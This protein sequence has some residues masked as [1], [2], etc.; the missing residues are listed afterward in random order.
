MEGIVLLMV[1]VAPW[2]Y[3]AVD[4]FSEYLLF[5]SVALIGALWAVRTA[6]D[7][8][9]LWFSCPI[10]LCLVLL[11]VLGVVQ[12]FPLPKY[13]A[14]IASPAAVSLNAELRPHQPE[15]LREGEPPV[16]VTP[17][18]TISVYP[19]ATQ[20][21]L[22][23][24]LALIVLFAAIRVNI[25]STAA[26]Q[27][28]AWVAFAT[29]VA[30]SVF[31]VYQFAQQRT[32]GPHVPVK[33]FGNETR[34]IPFGPFICRNHFPDFINICIGLAIGLLLIS[35]RTESD[36]RA[37]RT[38]KAQALVEQT[39]ED[40]ST[41]TLLSILHSPLQ[42]WLAVGLAI[43]AGAVVCSFSRGGVVA[44]FLGL[45]V[46][47]LIRGVPSA[48]RV[49]RLELLIIPALL[50]VGLL[51]WLGIKPLESRLFALNTETGS[52]GRLMIWRN[53]LPLVWRFPLF[54][55]GAGT[56]QY[57]EP[58]TRS[59]D[60]I[61]A[62]GPVDLD[63][64]HNDYLEAL[65]EGGVGRLLLTIAV[66]YFLIRFGRQ[67]MRRHELRTPGRM[68][69]GALIGI[70]AL[71]IH[72]FVDFGFTTPAV[73]WLAVVTA[74]YLS[75]MARSDP[76]EPPTRKSKHAI[77]VKAGGMGGIA[78]AVGLMLIGLVLLHHG[79]TATRV[80]QLR[81]SAFQAMRQMNPPNPDLA[82]T[83]LQVAVKMTPEN[84]QLRSELGQVFLDELK[85]QR[86][87]MEQRRGAA[88][89]VVL[90]GSHPLGHLVGVSV[91]PIIVF[92]SAA[93]ARAEFDE[94]IAPGLTNMIAARD[95]CPLLARPHARLAL[96]A[97]DAHP[98]SGIVMAKSDPALDYWARAVRLTPFDAD[99]LYYYGQTLF[100]AGREDQ[101]WDVWRRSL[102]QK[103]THLKA[104]IAVASTKLS[105][106]ELINRLLPDDPVVLLEVARFMAARPDMND[107][108]RRII[109]LAKKSLLARS[110][111][112]DAEATRLLGQCHRMLGETEQAISM[113]RQAIVLAQDRY[114]WRYEFAEFL[115]SIGTE[116]SRTEALAELKF[117][118][119]ANPH[120]GP[121]NQLKAVIERERDN[122]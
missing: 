11:F 15:V 12:I 117:I 7:G 1:A 30:L 17:W 83:T 103:P 34:G 32:A 39:A 81:M 22:V 40:E 18:S 100:K 111:N 94:F 37:R 20:Q 66:V 95:R 72:S 98:E 92:P 70:A 114:D 61:E 107:S 51:M 69:F 60:Y 113:Y 85:L 33:V 9:F 35:G 56:L 79:W 10:A 93:L 63:H 36:K 77:L 13:V 62:R 21:W 71:A 115:Y 112:L 29:G 89:A 65:I 31:A 73:T 121:A 76:S 38:H 24:L 55:S 8:H 46:T 91:T 49:A 3:G 105:A 102:Q 47:L 5:A 80:D 119:Q 116:R 53:L 78:A 25:A 44:L 96:Y 28:L 90:S 99:L 86:Q 106:D 104:I 4:P 45:I 23:R 87:A 52:T 14:A 16:A 48:R 118:L 67:A 54:G 101:A 27:R 2:L 109:L 64:A 59:I 97:Y 122:R 68:A 88:A 74:A 6:I 57:V 43:M 19:F 108:L 50:V 82:R 42:L 41:L 58:L 84:A 110:D 120:S 26:L 75:A